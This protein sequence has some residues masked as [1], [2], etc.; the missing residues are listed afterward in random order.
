MYLPKN[1]N[2]GGIY[3]RAHAST[4]MHDEFPFVFSTCPMRLMVETAAQASPMMKAV[5][6][7]SRSPEGD[8]APDNPAL[9][10]IGA[11]MPGSNLLLWALPPGRSSSPCSKAV[12]Q[13]VNR[14]QEAK[15]R[16]Q[17]ARQPNPRN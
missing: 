11:A 1:H 17:S 4:C 3:R 2:H 5:R 9:D 10:M 8:T 16:M 15:P 13:A 7:E 12:Q 14:V 6:R